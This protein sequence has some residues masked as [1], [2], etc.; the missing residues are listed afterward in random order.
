M[1]DGDFFDV[2]DKWVVFAVRRDE[3]FDYGWFLSYFEVQ[4]RLG[5]G[6]FGFVD[7]LMNSVNGECIAKKTLQANIH[8]R[9]NST[10][11]A[12]VESQSMLLIDNEAILRLYNVFLHNDKVVLLTEYLEGGTLRKFIRK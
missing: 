8:S 6:G 5:E 9:K 1:D 7:L 3:P 4:Q 10:I 12:F 2:R 11:S